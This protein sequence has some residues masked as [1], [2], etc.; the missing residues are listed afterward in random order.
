M[1]SWCALQQD[2]TC[3]AS[4]VI[5]LPE[6]SGI[7]RILWV[8]D[9]AYGFHGVLKASGR[10]M[11]VALPRIKALAFMVCVAAG[12][13]LQSFGGDCFTRGWW[14]FQIPWVSDDAY[15]PH[16]VHKAAVAFWPTHECGAAAHLGSCFRGVRR[17]SRGC[18]GYAA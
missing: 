9:D 13:D 18:A 1:L 10:H 14:D 11:N 8:S 15:G 3:K 5:A 7:S 17:C 2:L 4:V 6:S 12:S 16:R